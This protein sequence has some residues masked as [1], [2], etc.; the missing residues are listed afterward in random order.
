MANLGDLNIAVKLVTDGF[1]S[2]VSK[3]KSGLSSIGASVISLNQ[4]LDLLS[5]GFSGIKSVFAA[6][7]SA[8][9]AG[10]DMQRLE[11]AFKAITGSS[12]AAGKEI[13]WLR[14]ETKRLGQDFMTSADAYKGFAAA[15]MGTALEGDKVRQI[16]SS[17]SGAATVLGLSTEQVNGALFA[18]SQMISKGTVSSEEL[19]LQLGERLPGAVQLAA[20]AM[21]MSMAEFTDALEKGK[22]KAVDFL[23]KLASLLDE[24]YGAGLE[25]ASKSAQANMNRLG[26]A[27]DQLKQKFAEGNFIKTATDIFERLSIVFSNSQF[28]AGVRGVGDS[29][30]DL[31]KAVMDNAVPAFDALLEAVATFIDIWNKIPGAIKG[32]IVGSPFGAWGA[33]AGGIAGGLYSGVTGDNFNIDIDTDGLRNFRKNAIRRGREAIDADINNGDNSGPAF[34]PISEVNGSALEKQ[35][36]KLDDLKRL[37]ANAKAAHAPLKE[38][39]AIQ[40]QIVRIEKESGGKPPKDTNNGESAIRT[41]QKAIEETKALIASVDLNSIEGQ[42][43]GV[44]ADIEGMRIQYGKQLKGKQGPEIEALIEQ[45][46]TLRKEAIQAQKVIDAKQ[47]LKDADFAVATMNLSDFGKEWAAIERQFEGAQIEGTELGNVLDQLKDKLADK[48]VMEIELEV[49]EATDAAKK[50]RMTT[51]GAG[52]ADIL[53]KWSKRAKGVSR[54]SKEFQGIGAGAKTELGAYYDQIANSKM[55]FED[56]ATN[57]GSFLDNLDTLKET[58][59][60]IGVDFDEFK[61]KGEDAFNV[62]AIGGSVE[63]LLGL[64]EGPL[65]EALTKF[66]QTG[67]MN[68]GEFISSLMKTLQAYAAQKTAHLL[69]EAAYHGIMAIVEPDKGHGTKAAEAATGAAIMGSFVLGSGL[70]NMAHDGM[71]YIPEDGTWL[72]QKGERVVNDDTNKGLSKMVSEWNEGKQSTIG[73]MT[74]NI[75]NSDEAG[76]KKALPDLKKTII[77]AVQADISSNGGI[78]KA[79]LNYT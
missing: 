62:S 48:Y 77:E 66:A 58:F 56:W 64:V 45:L 61:K 43:A 10:M 47:L 79:I 46:R 78:R 73:S 52:V 76:V 72:L 50:S 11:N 38:I 28:K 20:K 44:D 60:E 27:W 2:G 40:Q 15:A 22:V 37:L 9:G 71:G 4:G 33:A 67:E 30:G 41:L 63:E 24:L 55:P 65:T 8:L 18:L 29:F 16:F 70:A 51:Q 26:N 1:S 68:F 49:K 36:P 25:S 5:R 35:A 6:G 59:A 7:R 19:K 13:Q 53:G 32:M 14:D 69:M 34:D 31:G 74:V 12:Q 21:G 54:D 75:N 42:L 23:P 17:V 39:L 57:L 3:I